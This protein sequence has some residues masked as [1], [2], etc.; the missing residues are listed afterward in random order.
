MSR[1]AVDLHI[2]D[3]SAAGHLMIGSLHL[4]LMTGG[5][6]IVDGHMVGVGVIVTIRHS[7][8][9]AELLPVLLRELATESLCGC[10]Q[11]GVVVMVLLA[12]VVDALTH[13]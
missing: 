5:T 3:M 9:L 1:V 4:G 7:R 13:I 12:E 11:Y 8:N 6:L 10:S 2:E